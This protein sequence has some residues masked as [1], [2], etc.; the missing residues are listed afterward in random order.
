MFIVQRAP[1][2]CLD[3][4][5]F[6]QVAKGR[7]RISNLDEHEVAHLPAKLYRWSKS[8]IQPR[9]YWMEHTLEPPAWVCEAK[10]L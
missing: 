7:A 3:V 10:D 6:F 2:N 9:P 4:C 1:H 8:K 5:Q